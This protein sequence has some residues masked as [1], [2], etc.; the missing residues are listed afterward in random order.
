MVNHLA[1]WSRIYSLARMPALMLLCL[2]P[3]MHHRDAEEVASRIGG[4]GPDLPSRGG[5]AM[6]Q[7][8]P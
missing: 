4:I 1:K 3:I 8:K 2:V 6:L 7:V 5:L